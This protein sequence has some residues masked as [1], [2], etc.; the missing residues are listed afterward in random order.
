MGNHLIFIIDDSR[1][2]LI[3]LKKVLEKAGFTVRMFTNGY[4]LIKSLE[5]EKPDLVI[6]DVDMP[7]LNGFELIGKVQ[8]KFEKV[9]FPFFFISASWSS[10]IE[11]R[12]EELGADRLIEKPFKFETMIN[13]I[14]RTLEQAT[15]INSSV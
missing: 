5:N 1:I 2:Q 13:E 7:V 14:E 10:A 11:K 15:K 6:S 8:K 12:A 3:L 4:N 9:S